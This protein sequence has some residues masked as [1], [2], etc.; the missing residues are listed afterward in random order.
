MSTFESVSFTNAYPIRVD[1][2]RNR[3]FFLIKYPKELDISDLKRLNVMNR[4]M[5]ADISA[6]VEKQVC[7]FAIED[8]SYAAY[9]HRNVNNHIY[10]PILNNHN[11]KRKHSDISEG[12]NVTVYEPITN[13][14]TI[15]KTILFDSKQ[16]KESKKKNQN[17]DLKTNI[18]PSYVPVPQLTGLHVNCVPYGSHTNIKDLRK[19]YVQGISE[20]VSSDTVNSTNDSVDKTPKKHK[21]KDKEKYI[22]A[23]QTPQTITEARPE[24]QMSTIE[25]SSKKKEKKSKKE[26]K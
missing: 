4:N 13:V 6:G 15:N 9:T 2:K 10:T 21:K 1:E 3:N 22:V 11:L 5:A 24:E 7:S 26:K 16:N 8:Q 20:V 23:I 14:L 25:K 12:S 17:F 19:H 18:T